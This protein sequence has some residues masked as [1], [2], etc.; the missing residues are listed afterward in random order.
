MALAAVGLQTHIWN[1]NAKSVLLLIL[2]PLLLIWMLAAFFFLASL[3]FQQYRPGVKHIP[4]ITTYSKHYFTD[5]VTREPLDA[6]MEGVRRYWHWPMIVATLWMMLAFFFHEQMINM[7][8]GAR[9]ISRKENPD[10]YNLLENLCISRG[11]TMPNLC[12]VDQPEV[13]NAYASGISEQSYSI[14]LTSGLLNHLNT[15]E[16]EAVLGHELTHIMNRD[17]RLLIVC[18]VF[19]GMISFFCNM[20]YEVSRSA[21]RNRHT[22]ISSKREGKGAVIFLLIAFIVLAI[23]YCFAQILR[24][25]LSRSREYL[26]D[27]GSVELTKN[28]DAMIAALRKI[29][30]H[31]EMEGVSI[32]VKQMF[33]DSPPSLFG[34]METHPPIEERIE[35]LRMMGGRDLSESGPWK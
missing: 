17:V 30:G 14:T 33:I 11:I 26:A 24:F 16:I 25:A 35:A 9:Y 27:A 7:T 4:A 22:Y 5:L 23:G 13:L 29:S 34:L 1:N 28:P 31:S 21:M 8:T 20:V 2:F 6:A 10:I 19:V 12:I 32:D 15:D 18:V 3:T